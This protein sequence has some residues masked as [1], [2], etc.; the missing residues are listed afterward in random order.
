MAKKLYR[1][2]DQPST[3]LKIEH[4]TKI[5]YFIF[6][7]LDN[8]RPKISS[9]YPICEFSKNTSELA[10]IRNHIRNVPSGAETMDSLNDQESTPLIDVKKL[11]RIAGSTLSDSVKNHVKKNHMLPAKQGKSYFLSPE[12]STVW[13][14][15]QETCNCP[16]T[17]TPHRYDGNRSV[18]KKN[19]NALVGINGKTGS[20]CECLTV[21]YDIKD[22]RVVTAFPSV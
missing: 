19:F 6:F 22:D 5:T 9:K 8:S 2:T 13:R 21:I 11:A 3:E 12:E 14:L 7:N 10:V 15:V 18:L 4:F 20:P 17:V 1:T 16:D